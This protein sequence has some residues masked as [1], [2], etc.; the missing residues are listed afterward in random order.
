MNRVAM[1]AI[2]AVLALVPVP[3]ASV[4]DPWRALSAAILAGG[5][6]VFFAVRAIKRAPITVPHAAIAGAVFLAIA[7]MQ[8]LPIGVGN[9]AAT[10]LLFDGESRS[11]LSVVPARTLARLGEVGALLALFVVAAIVLHE[12]RRR[13]IFALALVGIATVFASHGLAVAAGWFDVPWSG[14]DP[15]VVSSTFFNR[16]H[17]AGLL[18]VAILVGLGRLLS[19]AHGN[20]PRPV[21]RLFLAAA[22][23][24]CGIALVGT[25]SRGGV[26][27]TTCGAFAFVIAGAPK[28]R[29]AILLAVGVIVASIAAS[30]APDSFVDRVTAID[31]ELATAGRRPDIWLGAWNAFLA[32][33]LFGTGLG[34]FGDVSV[35][36]QSATVPGH[37]EHAHCDPLQIAVEC[38]IFGATIAALAFA[39]WLREALRAIRTTPAAHRLPIAGAMAAVVAMVVHS[40]VEF[41]LQIPADA[42]WVAAIAGLAVA[43]GRGIS[44]RPP[45]LWIVVAALALAAVDQSARAFGSHPGAGQVESLA[46]TALAR[47]PR[48]ERGHALLGAALQARHDDRARAAIERSLALV[49]A[50]ERPRFRLAAATS[51]CTDG[52]FATAAALTHSVLTES[53]ELRRTAI[54]QVYAALPSV[55]ALAGVFPRDDAA[56]WRELGALLLERGEFADREAA[57]AIARGETARP[58][59]LLTIDDGTR[60]CEAEVAA[61]KSGEGVCVID[62]DTTFVVARG[63]APAS[64]AIRIRGDAA[65]FARSFAPGDGKRRDQF[66]LDTT[67]PPGVYAIELVL[68][69]TKFPFPLDAVTVEPRIVELAVGRTVP[70]VEF[71][72]STGDPALRARDGA[73]VPLREGDALWSAIAMPAAGC[74]I[75]VVGAAVD[76]VR[77]WLD[78]TP[79]LLAGGS[80]RLARFR[81]PAGANP[82]RLE[83]RG[84]PGQVPAIESLF[85][86]EWVRR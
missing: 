52:D 25:G 69:G 83:L 53:P 21:E 64:V 38:G 29:R 43:G 57:L 34:T 2:L 74:E 30:L 82:R 60:L 42:T 62:V 33:P 58:D 68:G 24:T 63:V 28:P 48:A 4:D 59:S 77:P 18:A 39:L 50:H 61:S 5:A 67:T 72:W 75:A 46:R 22:L 26:V 11:A 10:G 66:V 13:R 85:V 51:A 3:L 35:G 17:L 27:A 76:A 65:V 31:D 71:A 44:V 15:S 86:S 55:D 70:A 45:I 14:Q 56:A 37:V 79:L 6:A 7:A 8:L 78:G 54:E 36:W 41:D 19:R 16:N 9:G 1:W 32:F 73:G 47:H 84:A 49:N 80:A 81:L 20:R 23:V 40:L 12:T